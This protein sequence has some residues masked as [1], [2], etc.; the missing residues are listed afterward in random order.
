MPQQPPPTIVR[1]RPPEREP[2]REPGR[3]LFQRILDTGERLLEQSG[4]VLSEIGIGAAKGAG[5]T[6][7]NLS[8]L[9]SRVPGVLPLNELLFGET[10][11]AYQSRIAGQRDA[12]EPASGLQ[13]FGKFSEQAAELMVP[14]GTGS[15]LAQAS[16]FS[17]TGRMAGEA[18]ELGAKVGIQTLEPQQAATAALFSVASTPVVRLAERAGQAVYRHLPERLYHQIFRL[19]R[20]DLALLAR[21][22]AAGLPEN[23]TLAR[24][25]MERGVRG[26]LTNMTTFVLRQLQRL[27]PQVQAVTRRMG[28]QGKIKITQKAHFID[29]LRSIE[30]RFGKRFF[31]ETGEE[32]AA[33]RQAMEQ[34][35]G[36]WIPATIAL[37]TKR[38]LDG[39]RTR[40]AFRMDTR[41]S[42]TQEELKIAADLMRT[43][44]R[45]DRRFAAL[46]NEE[47]IYMEALDQLLD[48]A[49]RKSNVRLLNLT[50]VIL[51]GGGLASGFPGTGLGA[52]AAVRG[53]QQ[54]V[55]LT[56]LGTAL[57]ATGRVMPSAQSL[58]RLGAGEASELVSLE[59]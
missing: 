46:M 48:E 59:P 2:A 29:L 41:L 20:D 54:P 38:F 21:T 35:Q 49:V 16:R 52:M 50:D 13:S 58:G 15:K 36:N 31:H 34:S 42:G 43:T 7:T 22:R 51:G 25:V 8:E 23:P 37:R 53:F 57:N 24:E 30:R 9:A 39:M 47:R 3:T 45:G 33:L 1:R 40:S 32:A 44:L 17:R 14:L 4:Y 5:E 27:E 12:L 26:N 6:F 18:L 19:S 28:V 56:T 10:P 55:S 11:E